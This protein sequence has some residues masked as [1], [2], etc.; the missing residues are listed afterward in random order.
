MNW[1]GELQADS[2]WFS[3][4]PASIESVG[5]ME[6]GADFRRLRIG[7]F[8]EAFEQVEWK[9][10]LEFAQAGRPSF[11]DNY[12]GMK[13]LPYLDNVRVGNIMEPF[14]LDRLTS[15]RFMTFMERSMIDDAFAPARNL[16]LLAFG[17]LGEERMTW[18]IGGFRT[19]S[20]EFA[21]DV[22]DDGEEAV[23]A[24]LTGLLWYDEPSG[25]RYY[26]HVGG[27]YSF[28]DEDEDF[29][30]FRSRPEI[31]VRAFG[32][33]ETPFLVDTGRFEALNH[34]LFGAEALWVQ[35]PFSLQAEY[36]AAPVTRSGEPNL[37]F[38]GG[39]VY[40]SY[41]LTGEHRPYS[42]A[43]GAVDRLQPFE[44]FFRVPTERGVQMGRGAWEIAARFSSI[45]LDD[46]E[47][48]GGRLNE[49]TFGLNW[50]LNAYTKVTF[51]Y[52]HSDLNRAPVGPSSANAFG[53]RV[54]YDF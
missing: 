22:G 15:N 43:R 11:L 24:R 2:A 32:E 44:N 39:Y 35:G 50:Y 19:G 31:R 41:L 27:A 52:V 5:D 51:N 21:D 42:K 47:I 33:G 18:A 26:A 10:E 45:D 53:V 16:G 28:R 14:S 38:S 9:I 8:G 40:A 13:D 3:Q 46:Q 20:D 30:L 7:A 1:T 12:V 37:F 48:L 17:T 25:G 34:Q 4:T 29:A 6:D 36:V 49:Y 54:G 23:T